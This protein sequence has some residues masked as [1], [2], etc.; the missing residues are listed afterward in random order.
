MQVLRTLVRPII[1]RTLSSGSSP[2]PGIRCSSP[3]QELDSEPIAQAV[4]DAQW[5]GVTVRMIIEQDYV[6]R[7]TLPKATPRVGET[8]DEAVKRAQWTEY[9]R[10]I[11]AKTNRDILAALLRNAVDVK[12]DY[13]PKIFHQKFI[14]R[15]YD[16]SGRS[17]SA[18]LTGSTNFTHTGTHKN[19]NHIAIFNDR[20]ICKAYLLEFEEIR[21]GNFGA[22]KPAQERD[23]LHL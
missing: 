6:A 20:R 1:C 4:I 18:V 8:P 22:L 23:S 14:V 19:Y 10:P 7:D 5:R 21:S 12:A 3:F 15:D 2:T 17:S 13:N 11:S 16:G 9:R